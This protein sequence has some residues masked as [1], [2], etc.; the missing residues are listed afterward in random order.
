MKRCVIC[1]KE[2][3]TGHVRLMYQKN[4]RE[5][6]HFHANCESKFD[7]EKFEK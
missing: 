2:I 5:V 4:N 6:I 3:P 7:R 1:H